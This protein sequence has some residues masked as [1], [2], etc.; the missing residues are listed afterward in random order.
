MVTRLVLCRVKIWTLADG[1]CWTLER[2][3]L[4]TLCSMILTLFTLARAFPGS[5]TR[6]PA[7]FT[8]VLYWI[9]DILNG[10]YDIKLLLS[11]KLTFIQL[12]L[13]PSHAFRSAI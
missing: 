11:S 13:C 6:E 1:T 9:P 7:G 8:S 3:L 10:Y 5:E 2:E 4:L 12:R